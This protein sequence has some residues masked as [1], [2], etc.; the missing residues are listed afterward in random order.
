M[1]RV[2]GIFYGDK[3]AIRFNRKDAIDLAKVNHGK[4]MSMSLFFFN[5]CGGSF[6]APTFYAQSDFVASFA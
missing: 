6:D 5:N 1:K 3:W 2:Y 4:I